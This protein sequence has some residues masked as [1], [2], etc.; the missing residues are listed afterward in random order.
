MH[1][2]NIDTI[3]RKGKSNGD[4]WVIKLK[5]STN[6]VVY[7]VAVQQSI[8]GRTGP[9][10]S[11]LFDNDGL[12]IIDLGTPGSFDSF[13]DGYS[14]INVNLQDVVKVIITHG[15]SD[16]DG[17]VPEFISHTNSQLWAHTNYSYLKKYKIWEIQ[18]RNKTVLQKEL[19]QI[20]STKINEKDSLS[21]R[22]QYSDYYELRKTTTSNKLNDGDIIGDLKVVASPGHSPDQ[23]CLILDDFIFTGDHV[24]P[25]IT[26]HP[27][28]E[29][30]I[31]ENVLKTLPESFIHSDTWFGLNTY[32]NSLGKIISLGDQYQLIPAHR[33]YNKDKFNWIGTSRAVEIITHHEKRLL[34]IIENL[35]KNSNSLEDLTKGVFEKSKLIGSNLHAAM[36]EIVAHIELLIIS[37]DINISQDGQIDVIKNGDNF[38][39]DLAKLKNK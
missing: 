9:T 13:L 19:T 2:I 24:L 34:R 20:I 12:T 3:I 11:Y 39:K 25:E 8:E 26:P 33:L 16:H 22:D 4:G 32:L 15:H 5:T 10:W 18:D 30:V 21:K 27:T 14:Q 36:S 6:R 31:I 37:D 1:T 23:I 7:A 38:I 35:S 17:T 28:T 29:T